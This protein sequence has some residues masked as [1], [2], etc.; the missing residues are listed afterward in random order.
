MEKKMFIVTLGYSERYAFPTYQE[1]I[2]FASALG[3]AMKVSEMY[4]GERVHYESEN[5]LTVGIEE[6]IVFQSRD[7]AK[8][9]SENKKKE[10]EIKKVYETHL[11]EQVAKE[12]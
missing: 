12:E 7:Q 5:S 8:V 10:E 3:N 2:A 6:T 1:A 9:Y 4:F 11:K